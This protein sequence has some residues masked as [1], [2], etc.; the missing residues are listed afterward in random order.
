MTIFGWKQFLNECNEKFAK[1][2]V[3]LLPS[4]SS[5]TWPKNVR[6]KFAAQKKIFMKTSQMKTKSANAEDSKTLL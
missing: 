2:L 5:K 4:Q 6:K 1:K 3:I